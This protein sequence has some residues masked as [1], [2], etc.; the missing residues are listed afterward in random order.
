M[1]TEQQLLALVLRTRARDI[2]LRVE[3]GERFQ[4]D[5][6]LSL[7]VARDDAM[8]VFRDG[9]RDADDG[10][11]F[12]PLCCGGDVEVK[13]GWMGEMARCPRCNVE[14]VDVLSP[15]Y[16]PILERGNACVTTPSEKLVKR[17]GERHWLIMH[18]GAGPCLPLRRDA[19]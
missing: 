10:Y 19:A 15:L 5:D 17:I 14:A 1:N 7:C 3:A 9:R 8:L 11:C 16:S 12:M 13:S 2:R 18:E 4:L 6:V